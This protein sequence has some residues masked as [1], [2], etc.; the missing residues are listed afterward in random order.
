MPSV[1]H[2][3]SWGESKGCLLMRSRGKEVGN[4]WTKPQLRAIEYLADGRFTQADIEKKISISRT[5]LWQ[6][7]KNPQFMDAVIARAYERVQEHMPRIL[8]NLAERASTGSVGHIRILLDH[9]EKLEKTRSDYSDHAINF[10]W[11]DEWE[12]DEQP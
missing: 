10:T 6:W 1:E 7:K 8:T 2:R 3:L 5:T 11:K 9:L 12:E 4:T